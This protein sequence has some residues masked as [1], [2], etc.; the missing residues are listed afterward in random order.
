[1]T[2]SR[3]QELVELN[4]IPNWR[5]TAWLVM[6]L[7][8][9]FLIWASFLTIREVA[10]ASGIFLSPSGLEK[11]SHSEG[12]IVEGIHVSDGQVINGDAPLILIKTADHGN[13]SNKLKVQL[14]KLSLT[15][16]RLEAEVKGKDTLIYPENLVKRL[17]EEVILQRQK[18][19]AGR[20]QLESSTSSLIQKIK[21]ARS[22]LSDLEAQVRAVA[23][24]LR[25]GNK[26]FE[27][28]RNLLNEG[29]IVEKEHLQIEAEIQRLK[30]QAQILKS[31][32][33]QAK[34]AVVDAETQIKVMRNQFQSA[35]EEELFKTE[36][37]I[38]GIERMLASSDEEG[39]RTMIR[40]P[41]DGTVK[42]LLY[43]TVG[44]LVSPGET[45]M[46]IVPAEASLV[47][48]ARL[49]PEDRPFV[50]LNQLATVKLSAYDFVRFGVLKG[51]VTM[52]APV[53]SISENGVSF[54]KVLVQTNKSF[55]GEDPMLFKVSP[56][57][58][59]TVEIHTGEK[60]LMEYLI[61]PVLQ[62]NHKA[63]R[64]R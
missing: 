64:E 28:S 37:Q 30:E 52:V 5:L 38:E 6:L 36:K 39:M 61:M 16:I 31:S 15:K 32:L 49:K 21:S 54:F 40:S 60:S 26:R 4:N 3:L 59:A 58:L 2:S 8:I 25:M 41:I 10:V 56:G 27:M 22:E 48:E 19:D 20:L 35:A 50:A 53:A 33:P 57:M 7:L 14:D 63:F 45:I 46:E 42:N 12:G 23:N 34:E 17:H 13:N 24:N 18:F 44:E 47:V 11:I 51:H 29:L 1:M 43:D 55:L 9:F 62:L